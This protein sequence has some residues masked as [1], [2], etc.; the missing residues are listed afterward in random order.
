MS[1]GFTT[2]IGSRSLASHDLKAS[3]LSII[4][5]RIV[6]WG[7]GDQ[8]LRLSILLAVLLSSSGGPGVCLHGQVG[9]S[10]L[11]HGTERGAVVTHDTPGNCGDDSSG[12]SDS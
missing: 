4:M 11:R 5:V 12:V 7:T 2:H 8:G 10:A 6:D 9:Q 3:T 1:Q